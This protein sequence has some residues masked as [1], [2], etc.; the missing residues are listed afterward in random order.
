MELHVKS[1]HFFKG[2]QTPGCSKKKIQLD[3]EKGSSELPASARCS[4]A[5]SLTALLLRTHERKQNHLAVSGGMAAQV[6]QLA[7]VRAQATTHTQTHIN[8]KKKN[9]SVCS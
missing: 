1:I 5:R 6:A 8:Q 4:G 9:L 7:E 2:L 3:T